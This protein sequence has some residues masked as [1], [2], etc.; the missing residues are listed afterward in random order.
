MHNLG[1]RTLCDRSISRR[2]PLTLM[3]PHLQR[4]VHLEHEPCEGLIESLRQRLCLH[5][6]SLSKPFLDLHELRARAR[7]A[8]Q[9]W[10]R[11]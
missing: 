9:A 8:E 5:A 6:R 3:F 2:V 11:A 4:H 10:E 7:V 1:A